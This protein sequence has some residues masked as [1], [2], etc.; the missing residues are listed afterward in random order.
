MKG[1]GLYRVLSF[2]LSVF[3]LFTAFSFLISVMQLFQTFNAAIHVF[4][5]LAVLL[6]YWYSRKFFIEVY[7]QNGSFPKRLKD[8]L[9]VNAFV[10]ILVSL[11]TAGQTAYW[12]ISP[13]GLAQM[14]ATVQS[15]LPEQSNIPEKNVTT[16][17]KL[18][19]IAGLLLQIIVLT[20][21][22]WTLILLRKHMKQQK[23]EE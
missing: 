15:I 8:R 11:F 13:E 14:Q 1:L 22:I 18:G 5:N 9:Q 4:I 17:L 7:V 21:V 10:A 20:H 16:N 12:L 2:F 19:L 23:Q 6:Y 3:C